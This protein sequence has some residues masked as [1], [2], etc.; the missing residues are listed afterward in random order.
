VPIIVPVT[1]AYKTID[2]QPMTA[3]N[4]DLIYWYGDMDFVSHFGV[5]WRCAIS[6]CW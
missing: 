2:E 3:A 5:F 4:R 1:I 6:K